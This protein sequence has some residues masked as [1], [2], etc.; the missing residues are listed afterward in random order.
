MIWS[1]KHWKF[2]TCSLIHR[3]VTEK[4]SAQDRT[5]EAETHGDEDA[6]KTFRAF[7]CLIFTVDAH[8]WEL[9]PVDSNKCLLALV[10]VAKLL[11][12]ATLSIVA[13]RAAEVVARLLASFEVASLLFSGPTEIDV[14][15]HLLLWNQLLLHLLLRHRHVLRLHLLLRNRHVLRL[16]R[17]RLH[18]LRLHL[19]LLLR[20][21]HLLLR[22]RHVLRLHGLTLGNKWL[23]NVRRVRLVGFGL[24]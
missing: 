12:T 5:P 24:H 4:D 15:W 11:S 1:I 7:V 14:N 21:C 19:H 6:V 8:V 16:H 17:L 18:W 23:L 10:L 13:G 20:H 3:N 2:N 22:Y 9:T